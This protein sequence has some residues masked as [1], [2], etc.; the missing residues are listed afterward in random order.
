MGKL[1]QHSEPASTLLFIPDISGFTQFV[2]TTEISHSQHII[3]ELLEVIIDANML[4]LEVSEVEGD[5]ILFYRN[6]AAPSS[7]ELLLQVRQMY[8]AFHAHLKKYESRR[9]CQCGACSTA[10]DLTLKFVTHFGET[11]KNQV[12]QFTK[13]FGADVIIAHRLLKNDVPEDEYLLVTDSLEID[14]E[15]ALE[16]AFN[17]FE[18]TET[19]YDVGLVRFAYLGLGSLRDRIPGPEAEDFGLP[20]VTVKVLEQE[21][22]IQA[23]LAMVFDVI[24]DVSFRHRW[25]HGLL[26]S[27]ELNHKITQNGSTHRCIIKGDASDPAFV[28]HGFEKKGDTITFSDTDHKIGVG[29]VFTLKKEGANRTRVQVHTFLK[30]HPFKQLLFSLVLKKRFLRDG[31]VSW[32]N[33]NKYCQE[34]QAQGLSHEAQ[35]LL[36]PFVPAEL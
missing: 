4:G 28:S 33:L 30:K 29:N 24:S 14:N 34:L 17:A 21:A 10:N 20:G 13:L 27:D 35:I 26:G 9:I 25:Q 11:T 36:E 22:I 19:V 3:E 2:N 18:S 7:K 5:A 16:V 32:K 8:T 12:K 1:V 23:P 15:L 6:G 31:Q